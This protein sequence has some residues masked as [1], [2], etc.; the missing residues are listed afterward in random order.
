MNSATDSQTDAHNTVSFARSAVRAVPVSARGVVV[1]RTHRVVR[2]RAKAM[3]ERRSRARS[4][5]APLVICSVML[6]LSILAVWTGMYQ[7]QAVEAVE[8]DVSALAQADLSD[9]ALVALMWFV[10]VSLALITAVFVRRSRKSRDGEA[11]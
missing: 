5:M 2:E 1:N 10:P 8:A 6:I 3:Q 11:L 4:L 7:Y 9:H